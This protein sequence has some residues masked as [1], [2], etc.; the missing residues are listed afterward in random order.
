MGYR[1]QSAILYTHRG[2]ER[3][4]CWRWYRSNLV[5]LGRENVHIQEKDIGD[6]NGIQCRKGKSNL[7]SGSGPGE[8]KV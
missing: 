1:G 5:H 6:S 8:G 7:S 3:P 4:V 2:R